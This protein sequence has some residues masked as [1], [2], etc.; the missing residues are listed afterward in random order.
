MAGRKHSIVHRRSCH[1]SACE[2]KFGRHVR[3]LVLGVNIFDLDL[4]V[5]SKFNLST[6]HSGATLWVRYTN[7]TVELL[8]VKVILIT[9][10]LS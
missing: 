2:T 1:S 5:Q 6:C 8:P 10:S 7:L 4:G 3:A 9:P